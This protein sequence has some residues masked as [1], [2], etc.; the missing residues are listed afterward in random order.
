[1]MKK[2]VKGV[3]LGFAL[4][5]LSIPVWSAVRLPAL[6]SDNMVLQQGRPAPI[7]GWADKG[8][9]V[10]V[11]LGEQLYTTKAGD[12]GRWKIEL[13]KLKP[14]NVLEMIVKGSSGNSLT[15]KNILVGEVWICSGQSNM[16]WTFSKGHGVLNNE[17]ELANANYN[18]IRMFT[19]AKGGTPE[20]AEDAKGAWLTINRENLLVDG[21]NGASV[22]AYFFGRELFQKLNI[23]VGLIN[24]SVGGTPAEKWTKREALEANPDLKALSGKGG[25]STLYNAMIA[26]LIPYAIR[27]AIWYQG[28]SNLDR[29]YQYR[30]LFPAMIANWRSEWKQGNFPFGF[31]QI[32]PYRYKGQNPENYPELCEAQTMTLKSSPNTGMAVTADIGDVG[33]IHPKNKQEVGRRLALWAMAKVYGK[34]QMV[35]SGPLYKSMKIKG[36]QIVLNFDQR[37]SGLTSGD[38]KSLVE[39]TIAGADK[40]FVQAK[41]EIVG[42][43]IVVSSDKITNPV[44]VRYAWHDDAQPNLAN[45]EGLP[46]SSFRTDSWKGVTEK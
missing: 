42:N 21:E 36:N 22:L 3:M 16:H 26:P 33:N 35:Y 7:W 43:T 25:S 17:T 10:T 38:G 20:P 13:K 6:I 44:A 46:A 37:G 23:P 5:C 18:D 29:A 11:N 28:E 19:V 40:A 14:G 15:V 8:E 32:A 12:D 31:V 27:G 34:K 39:F 45:K 2:L 1:M 30:T 9:V 41:A 24:T 4:V